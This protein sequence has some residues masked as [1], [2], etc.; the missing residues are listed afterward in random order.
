ML[1]GLVRKCSTARFVG[2]RNSCFWGRRGRPV[3]KAVAG[4]STRGQKPARAAFYSVSEIHPYG[5][6]LVLGLGTVGGRVE[7]QECAVVQRREWK[8]SLS[9]N[10]GVAIHV[11]RM[12][13]R[14]EQGDGDSL[15]GHRP[16]KGHILGASCGDA[17]RRRDSLCGEVCVC[18]SGGVCQSTRIFVCW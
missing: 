10:R 2:C 11:W 14:V 8:G 16:V 1:Y 6:T 9:T 15:R 5:I 12:A 3:E 17:K 18:G 7:T 13:V 4:R